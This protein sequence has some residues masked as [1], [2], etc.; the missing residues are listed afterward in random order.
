MQLRLH[1]SAEKAYEVLSQEVPWKELPVAFCFLCFAFQKHMLYL[2]SS[3]SASSAFSPL[4]CQT[5]MMESPGCPRSQCWEYHL[6][7][8]GWCHCSSQQDLLDKS[9]AVVVVLHLFCVMGVS[10]IHTHTMVLV[11]RSEDNL[12]QSVLSFC[13]MGSR[14]W[15]QV[16]RLSTLSHWGILLGKF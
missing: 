15:I 12:E 14:N 10:Y 2:K 6:C 16:V 5:V 4:A 1:Q 8:Y 7:V 13:H 9:V 11:W 3:P